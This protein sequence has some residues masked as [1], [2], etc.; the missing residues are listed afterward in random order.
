[1]TT[2]DIHT[3]IGAYALD[4]VDDLER[5][6][7]ERHLSDCDSCRT[8]VDELR[9]TAARLADNTW[10]APP[11]RLRTDV[12]AA[13]AHTRQIPPTDTGHLGTSRET[14]AVRWRTRAAAY[15]AAAILAAGT[16]A[17][18]Y[19]V[20]EQR[21]LEQ[22]AT[23]AATQLREARTQAI[24]AAPDLSVRTSAMTGGGRVTVASSAAQRAAVVALQ[25]DTPV[26]P[27]QALQLWTIRGTGSPVS[28][29]VLAAGQQQAAQ[30]IDGIPDHEGF[31]V[32][33]EPAGG[34]AQ[35]SNVLAQVNLA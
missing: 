30:V 9:L 15:A 19:A 29:G 14:P 25:T 23:A 20:Q 32:S 22:S 2:T 5:A 1:M 16:G 28:A 18:V 26:G 11:Q 7:F 12:M 35:P 10:S 27:D 17:T 13:I 31:A 21:V 8:D 24:L 6:A 4:A 3:L 34:S 33:L